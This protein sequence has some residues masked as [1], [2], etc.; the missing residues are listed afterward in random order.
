MSI[1][2][3]TKEVFTF[4]AKESKL[5]RWVKKAVSKDT[6][7]PALQGIHFGKDITGSDGYRLHKIP[8]AKNID[9]KGTYDLSSLRVGHN[10]L[11]IKEI[12]AK[13]P[14]FQDPFP[15]GDP[16]LEIAF[17]PKFII[18][19]CTG[20]DNDINSNVILKVWGKNKPAV[21]QGTIDGEEVIALIMPKHISE[22]NIPDSLK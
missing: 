3:S 14:D 21:F 2:K 17:N 6:A 12:T 9:L 13:T 18:D 10:L 4:L 5:L 22:S 15:E 20:L 8:D 11:E 1:Q 7:R 16:I 19:A